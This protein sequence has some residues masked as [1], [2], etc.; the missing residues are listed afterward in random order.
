M[1]KKNHNKA[2]QSTG[3]TIHS[4]NLPMVK[5]YWLL[6]FLFKKIRVVVVFILTETGGARI[7]VRVLVFILTD[8]LLP[9]DNQVPLS[10]IFYIMYGSYL[11]LPFK[12]HL[13]DMN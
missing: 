4:P 13:Q 11:N 9:S 8:S 12:L 7:K 6:S 10:E 1:Q 2:E 3:I 5:E